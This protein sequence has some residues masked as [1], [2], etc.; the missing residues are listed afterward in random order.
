MSSKASSH[1]F[2]LFVLLLTTCLDWMSIGLVYPMFSSMIFHPGAHFFSSATSDVVKGG[3]LGVLL[4]SGPLAQFFSAPIAGTLSDQRGRKLLLKN[5]L[6]I[7]IAGYLLCAFG[8][9]LE[10]LVLLLIGR[11]IV[12][13]GTGN[14]AVVYAAIADISRPEQKT[15][16]FGLASMASGIGFTLGPFSRGHPVFLGICH[17]LPLFDFLFAHQL[18]SGDFL[19]L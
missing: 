17:P 4:S 15:K 13:I 12:G 5:T 14:T 8:V 1:K 9:W 6:L 18:C 16:H 19:V 10:S 3:W 11:T 7:I 2:S